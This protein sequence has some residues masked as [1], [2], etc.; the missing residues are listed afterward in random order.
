MDDSEFSAEEYFQTQ[1]EPANLDAEIDGVRNFITRHGAKGNRVVL[2][3]VSSANHA[4][5]I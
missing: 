4:L 5:I 1:P 3:T 2:V